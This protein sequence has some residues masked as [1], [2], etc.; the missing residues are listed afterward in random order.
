MV[1]HLGHRV[2]Q[3]VMPVTQGL[4]ITGHRPEIIVGG[5]S[6]KVEAPGRDILDRGGRGIREG[7]GPSLVDI[8]E[9]VHHVY[10][11]GRGRGRQ[12]DARGGEGDFGNPRQGVFTIPHSGGISISPITQ[13]YGSICDVRRMGHQQGGGSSHIAQNNNTTGG[14]RGLNGTSKPDMLSVYRHGGVK[15]L[16]WGSLLNRG[17]RCYAQSF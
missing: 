11:H 10:H 12:E 7:R 3:L 16:R 8:I 2:Q 15:E 14:G 17:G 9:G 1:S 5:N 4:D 6:L 13:C